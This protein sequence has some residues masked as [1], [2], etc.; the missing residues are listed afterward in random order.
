MSI[1]G[2]H[3]IPGEQAQH[4]Y[5]KGCECAYCFGITQ[6]D[7]RMKAAMDFADEYYEQRNRAEESK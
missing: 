5:L 3:M 2:E 6:A 7:K 4:L 1:E